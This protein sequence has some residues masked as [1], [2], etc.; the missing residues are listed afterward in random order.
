VIAGGSL[1]SGLTLMP[2]GVH[3]GRAR[4]H[5]DR[6]ESSTAA[7]L[8]GAHIERRPITMPLIIALFLIAI[9][10]VAIVGF[11]LHLIFSPWLLVVLIGILAWIKLH[12]RRSR[13]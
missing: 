1:L 7:L 5:P 9:V 3:Q 10:A 8:R 2:S 11:M 6:L 12:P 13:L 4:A